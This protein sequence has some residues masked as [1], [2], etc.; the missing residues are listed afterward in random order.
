[1]TN[2][3]AQ[4]IFSQLGGNR[5]AMITGAKAFCAGENSLS[6]RLPG[7]PKRVTH[8][9]IDLDA[10]DTYTVK[11]LRIGQKVSA[12][13]VLAKISDI[14]SDMLLDCFEEHTG[15]Y[16]TLSARRA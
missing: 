14:Y 2:E 13:K 4:T 16:A 7:N 15:L 10:S 6:F 9:R 5:F 12:Y 3:I 11:F 8:V 1:M